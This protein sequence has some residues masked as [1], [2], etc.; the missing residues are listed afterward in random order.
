MKLWAIV[1]G[2][3]FTVFSVTAGTI[4]YE[5]SSTVG[6]FI[7]DADKVYAES[8]FR[9]DDDAESLGGEQCAM[10]DSCQLSGVARKITPEVIKAGVQAV[11]IGKDAISVVVNIRNPVTQLTQVQLKGIFSGEITNWSELGGADLKITPYITKPASAT[12]VVFQQKVMGDSQYS[13]AKVVSPDR[14]IV[15]RVVRDRGA[16]GQISLAF[17]KGIKRIGII[18]VDGQPASLDNPDY[19]ITRELYLLTH[20]APTGE[21]K[22]FIEWVLSPEGQDVLRQRFVG[23]N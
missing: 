23:I 2:G 12:H 16:I 3:L 20:R 1:A 21:V 9:I 15:S 4:S 7:A 19:P 11:L 5:G 22:T 6:K 14:K 8:T 17:L 10:W 18:T 13:G